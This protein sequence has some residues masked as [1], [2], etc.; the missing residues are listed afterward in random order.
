M[1]L[2]SLK[3]NAEGGQ[4]KRETYL[5]VQRPHVLKKYNENMG[6][7]DLCDRMIVHYRIVAKTEKWTVRTIFHFIDI[8]VSNSWIEYIKKCKYLQI[9]QKGV[10]NIFGISAGSY[11]RSL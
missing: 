8:S 5:E 10:K 3:I 7:I 2:S 11:R 1:K 9:P 6:G 4:R